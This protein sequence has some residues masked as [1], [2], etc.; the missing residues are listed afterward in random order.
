[1]SLHRSLLPNFISAPCIKCAS[2]LLTSH[3]ELCDRARGVRHTE[4]LDAPSSSFT[5]SLLPPSS[6]LKWGYKVKHN[7]LRSLKGARSYVECTQWQLLSQD[8][9]E[10][11]GLRSKPDA[12]LASNLP[13]HSRVSSIINTSQDTACEM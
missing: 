6:L 9:E 10:T 12:K 4:L 13:L 7:S 2:G 11:A 8:G 3:S 5:P 1:V